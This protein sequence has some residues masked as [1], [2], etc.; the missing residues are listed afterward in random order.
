MR[1]VRIGFAVTAAVGAVLITA[2]SAGAVTPSPS[3]PASGTLS[4][5]AE[6]QMGSEIAA[7]KPVIATYKGK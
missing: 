3:A 6:Q 1:S 5:A 7:S 2:P 4:P